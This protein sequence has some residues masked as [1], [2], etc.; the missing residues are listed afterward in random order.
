MIAAT[1]VRLA[2]GHAV[3]PDGTVTDEMIEESYR[4][5]RGLFEGM[6]FPVRT[7]PDMIYF[8]LS[9]PACMGIPILVYRELLRIAVAL[10]S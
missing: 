7:R 10:E 4:Y 3:V 9:S 5:L 8:L 6:S 2:E 1:M